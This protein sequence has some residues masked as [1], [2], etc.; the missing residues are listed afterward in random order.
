MTAPGAAAALALLTFALVAG[1]QTRA[2][3][4]RRHDHGA[5]QSA[6]ATTAASAARTGPAAPVPELTD[7][8]REAAFPELSGGMTHA[9]AVN[10][11]ILLDRLELR[12]ADPGTGFAWDAEAWFGSDI[13]RLWLRS[14]GERIDRVT[15][16]S[17]LEVLYGRSIAAWWDIVAGVKHDFKPGASRNWATLGVKGLMPGHFELA[18]LA[19]VA[20]A[21]HFGA[22][23]EVEYDLLIT[24]RLILQP[25]VELG[26]FGKSD[27]ERGVVAGLQAFEA[28]L[29][30]RYEFTR[31]FAPYI[32]VVHSRALGNTADQLAAEGDDRT[33]TA[34][35][36]GFRAWF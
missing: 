2:Q 36:A 27:P 12:D 7:A 13:N 32:G 18:A 34:V 22:G 24:N 29:R 35:V 21:G 23:I 11:F 33:R 20:E 16:G 6:P 31:Q 5:T 28:G 1:P 14:F 3:D 8:D 26:Y 4:H 19:Y 15:E 17:G 30:L 10:S 25:L 9:S